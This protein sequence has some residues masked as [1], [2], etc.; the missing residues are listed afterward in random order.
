M[1]KKPGNE[2]DTSTINGIFDYEQNNSEKLKQKVD[3]MNSQ[4][5]NFEQSIGELQAKVKAYNDII[6]K[7]E[8]IF[9]EELLLY[10]LQKTKLTTMQEAFHNQES[11]TKEIEQHVTS[12]IND[13]PKQNNRYSTFKRIILR[14]FHQNKLNQCNTNMKISEIEEL[15]N[16]K[17]QLFERFQSD[18]KNWNKK[19]SIAITASERQQITLN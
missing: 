15:I 5:K 14:F 1:Y 18:V 3:Q 12:Y 17:H 16:K 4:I 6:L 10:R 19:L 8:S 13:T 9:R 7:Y 2:P 11:F